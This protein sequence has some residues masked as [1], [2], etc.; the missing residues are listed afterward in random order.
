MPL[1]ERGVVVDPV[2]GVFHIRMEVSTVGFIYCGT[3]RYDHGAYDDERS[4]G[5]PSCLFCLAKVMRE[6]ETRG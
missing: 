6:G 1:I 2:H 5:V 4:R 3:G